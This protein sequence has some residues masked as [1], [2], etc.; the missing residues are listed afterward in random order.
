M[1][2][3]YPFHSM[4]AHINVQA[5]AGNRLH[6]NHYGC[7]PYN[8][9]SAPEMRKHVYKVTQFIPPKPTGGLPTPTCG[10]L[11]AFARAIHQNVTPRRSKLQGDAPL[12]NWEWEQ[13]RRDAD[14][15]AVFLRDWHV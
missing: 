5:A 12:I 8:T 6:V 9:V 7:D 1:S 11:P 10:S 14:R 15:A 2:R 4:H 3:N 13:V